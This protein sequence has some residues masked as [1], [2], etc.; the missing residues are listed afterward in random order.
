MT[1]KHT[2]TKKLFQGRSRRANLSPRGQ[3][4]LSLRFERMMRSK[5]HL[6]HRSFQHSW[7]RLWYPELASSFLG[8]RHGMPVINPQETLGATVRALYFAVLV[9]RNRGRLLLVDTRQEF[10]PLSHMAM[11]MPEVLPQALAVSGRRWIGG[12]LTNWSSLAPHVSQFGHA[13]STLQPAVAR[14]KLSTPRF[15]KMREAFPGFFLGARHGG[16]SLA[17]K[18]RERPDLLIICQ[19]KEN[20]LLLREAFSLQIPVIAF[21]DSNTCLDYITYPIP[22]NTENHEWIYHCIDL[23]SRIANC[24][25]EPRQGSRL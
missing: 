24:F 5:T 16:D 13:I 4:E 11:R 25:S 14:F 19:P 9:L 20:Q 2:S 1:K 6:G 8:F 15:K 3:G 17:L 7:G 18:F 22:V 23:L 10:S 21:V 12:T